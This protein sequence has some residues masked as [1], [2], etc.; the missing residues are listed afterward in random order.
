M[1]DHDRLFKGLLSANIWEFIELFMPEVKKFLDR[2]SLQL[3]DKEL[4]ADIP[5]FPRQ[6]ADLV[7]K[8]KFKGQDSYFLIQ[9]RIR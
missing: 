8:G 4:F 1:I 9:Q 2:D 3:V 6:E 5:G 7:F